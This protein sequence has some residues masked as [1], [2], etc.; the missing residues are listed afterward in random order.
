MEIHRFLENRK[1]FIAWGTLGEALRIGRGADLVGE[2]RPRM[3]EG[4][5]GGEAVSP[6]PG[7]VARCRPPHQGRARSPGAGHFVGGGAGYLARGRPPHPGQ[8]TSPGARPPRQGTHVEAVL[9][10]SPY[11]FPTFRLHSF[12]IIGYTLRRCAGRLCGEFCQKGSI[13]RHRP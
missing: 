13:D 7:Q 8:A 9:L 4:I 6:R 3:G 11:S 5:L 12:I 10:V 1:G 2:G